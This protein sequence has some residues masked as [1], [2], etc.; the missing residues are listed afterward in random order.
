MYKR[1]LIFTVIVLSVLG[2]GSNSYGVQEILLID[3]SDSILHINEK[4]IN[5]DRIEVELTDLHYEIHTDGHRSRSEPHTIAVFYMYDLDEYPIRFIKTND[6]PFESFDISFNYRT[7]QFHTT[8]IS[9][10]DIHIT[11][12]TTVKDIESL[13]NEKK[14]KYSKRAI[15][16]DLIIFDSSLSDFLIEQVTFNKN[17]IYSI[18]VKIRTQ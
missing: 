9:I 1:I 14:I 7:N 11:N 2:L 15:S 3:L 4:K 16:S 10:N 13:L 17:K 6:G 8:K 5:L 18:E 12:D